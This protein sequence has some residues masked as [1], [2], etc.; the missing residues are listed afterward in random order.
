M[1]FCMVLAGFNLLPASL[2]SVWVF[3]LVG[4]ASVLLV[5]VAKGGFGGAIGL[6]STPMMIYACGQDTT[7]ALAVLLPA[8]IACDFVAVAK[9][10]RRWD[11]RPVGLLLPGAVVGIAVGGAAF[12]LLGR[13]EH[14]GYK[15]QADAWLGMAIGAIALGFVVLQLWRAARA[16]GKGMPHFRPVLW[17]GSCFGA[18]AGFTS[19]L[20][21]AA[22][23]VTAM[24]LLPQGMPKD[25]YVA[26][27]ALYYWINNL[28]KVPV[29]VL[30]GQ[31]RPE[32][33]HASLVLLPA[34]VFGTW[35]GVFLNR[36]IGQTHFN[37]VVYV[38]LALAGG[39][40]VVSAIAK[41]GA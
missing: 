18:V 25:R 12:L 29:Y 38:L 19:T 24:Y 13:L 31:L 17:Q 36:R 20:A 41:L 9:W 14:E 21:H 30:A 27:N 4:S 39:H 8:L 34:V 22:G 28:L 10:W 11:W 1:S 26:S 7:L 32:A 23:P 3:L 6:L 16:R 15:K 35:L 33:L 37:V 40:L 5:A 2:P